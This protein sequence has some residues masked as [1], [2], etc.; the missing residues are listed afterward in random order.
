MRIL[1]VAATHGNE[2]LGIQLYERLLAT[3]SPL[4]E[5]IDFV[6][7]NP[8][9]YALRIRY[10]EY[11]L[12]RVYG[13]N[14]KS[15]EHIRSREIERYIKL[16]APD[17]V[18]DMHTTNCIQPACLIL[19][20]LADD[21]TRQYL[22]A[23][24]IS[25]ILQVTTTGDIATLDYPVIGYEVSRRQVNTQSIDKIIADMKTFINSSTPHVRKKLYK[26]YDNTTR[27]QNIY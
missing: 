14:G 27:H 19:H 3:H 18:L 10:T 17:I 20:N 8:K 9:A 2:L 25:H 15:Y 26:M 6:I 5:Y 24:H 11:D 22:R 1:I 12:N 4:L 16:T 21:T 23:S 7:G 13:K